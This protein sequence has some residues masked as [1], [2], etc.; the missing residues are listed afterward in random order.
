MTERYSCRLRRSDCIRQVAED[1]YRA[2]EDELRQKDFT[3][4]K[5]RYAISL[6]I[7]YLINY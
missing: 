2:L 4:D 3:N 6:M 5:L 7:I 1:K